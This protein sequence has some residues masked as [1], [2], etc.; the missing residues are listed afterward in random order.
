[1]TAKA[2]DIRAWAKDN[3]ME[4]ADGGRIPQD[5][6][7]AFEAAHPEDISE[8][9]EYE[10]VPESPPDVKVDKPIDRVRR[11]TSRAKSRTKRAR[12]TRPKRP[13]V[14]VERLI[15]GGWHM[16]AQIAQPISIPVSRTLGLQAPL[17]GMVLEDVVKG[18][19][20][21]TLLQPLARAGEKGEVGFALLGP[22]MIVFAIEQKPELW[23]VLRPMLRESLKSWVRIAGPKAELRM[24]EEQKFE[25]EYGTRIDSLIEMIFAAPEDYPNDISD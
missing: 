14:S 5:V 24:L 22:P 3:D 7:E 13:R 2:Q 6:R 23:P 20:A 21:D 15:E 19:V 1:M 8:D 16:L 12:T 18:T 9:E 17:A 10:R 25:E 4:I 11:F